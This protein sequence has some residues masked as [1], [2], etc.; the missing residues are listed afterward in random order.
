MGAQSAPCTGV[1]GIPGPGTQ[2]IQEKE[3]EHSRGKRGTHRSVLRPHGSY[4]AALV[5]FAHAES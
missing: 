4:L 1:R 2:H 5:T 3:R